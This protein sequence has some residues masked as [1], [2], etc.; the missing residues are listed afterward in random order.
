MSGPPE[1]PGLIGHVGLDQRQ[2]VAG[3]ARLGAD[4]AGRDRVLQAERRADRHDPFAHLE[5]GDVADAHRRQAAGLDLDQRHVRLLV[6]ADDLGLELALVGQGDRDLVGAFDDVR[7]GHHIAVGI[8]D[9]S[10]ADAARLRVA[11]AGLLRRARAGAVGHRQPEAA[12]EL[13]HVVVHVAARRA[14][15]CTGPLGGADV[16]DRRADLFDQLG[17][18]G[19]A[20][21][22]RWRRR[23]HQQAEREAGRPSWRGRPRAPRGRGAVA[24]ACETS[25][26]A[27]RV[28]PWG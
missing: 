10:R 22:R 28:D 21:R 9:E 6:G 25:V 15:R 1:L 26:D 4:D 12:E 11:V 2:Q 24:V 23:R 18:I 5:P 16:D 13:E 20:L 17:E 7:V 27:R 14:A 8:E 19:Q 3:V